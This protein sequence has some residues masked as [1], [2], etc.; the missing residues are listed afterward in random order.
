MYKYHEIELTKWTL[1]YNGF[2]CLQRFTD[3]LLILST[4]SEVIF[5]A[6]FQALDVELCDIFANFFYRCPFSFPVLSLFN[7]VTSDWTASII[8]GSLPGQCKRILS[9][10]LGFQR[11]KWLS[12]SI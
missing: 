4:N 6:L 2:L 5:F 11:S 12:W 1:G 9:D 8:F 3:S 7:N 10:V